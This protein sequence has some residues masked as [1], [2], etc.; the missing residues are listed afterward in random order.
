MSNTKNEYANYDDAN[1]EYV[2]VYNKASSALYFLI[3]L[4]VVS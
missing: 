2:L 4:H 1:Y 3:F